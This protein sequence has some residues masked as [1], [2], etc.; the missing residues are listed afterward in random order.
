MTNSQNSSTA[1]HHI[2]AVPLFY[3][4]GARPYPLTLTADDIGTAE[5]LIL[6]REGDL[7]LLP[8]RWEQNLPTD[9]LPSITSFYADALDQEAFHLTLHDLQSD[10]WQVDGRI[11]LQFTGR[12]TDAHFEDNINSFLWHTPTK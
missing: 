1:I 2:A 11:H 8:T 3:W 12:E 9:R 5:M 6:S 4:R 10:G 7:C